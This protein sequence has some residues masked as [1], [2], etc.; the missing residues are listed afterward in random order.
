LPRPDAAIIQALNDGAS[1]IV[2]AEVFLPISNHA[3]EGKDLIEALRVEQQCGVPVSFTGPLY[4]SGPL[5]QMFV[6]RANERRD[7]QVARGRPAGGAGPA[8]G[9][10]S[11]NAIH[12]QYDIPAQ[13]SQARVPEGAS[14][15]NMGAWNDHPLAIEA[16]R[17]K[18]EAQLDGRGSHRPEAEPVALSAVGA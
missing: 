4:D 1:G 8:A 3:A 6:D 9:L 18:I 12:S 17:R 11:A 10:V 2:V 15:I 16:I 7:R 5:K 13:V 14:L